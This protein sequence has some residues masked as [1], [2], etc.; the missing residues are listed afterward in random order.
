MGHH[1]VSRLIDR[2]HT[3]ITDITINM[4]SSAPVALILGSGPN[5]GLHV[6]KALSAKGYK[7]ATVSRTAKAHDGEPG[8]AKFEVDLSQPSS[9]AHV[10]AKVRA[11]VGIPSIVIYNGEFQSPQPGLSY[12]R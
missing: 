8:Q 4:T 2:T 9:I 12:I 1:H 11:T 3:D 6:A 5:V 7:I 10:F